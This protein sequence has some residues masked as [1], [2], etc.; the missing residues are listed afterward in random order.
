MAPPFHFGNLSLRLLALLVHDLF[1]VEGVGRIRENQGDGIKQR[2]KAVRG[3]RRILLWAVVLCAGVAAARDI[4]LVAN[5]ANDASS[6]SM[7]DLSKIC[8]GQMNR[9]PDGKPVTLIMRDPGAPEM[10]LVLDKVYG[11][12]KS[13]VAGLIVT[14]NH[15]RANHPAIVVVG[16]DEDLVN[17][18]QATPGS[19]GLVDVYSINGGI[20]VLKLGGKLPL[21]PG[22]PLHGN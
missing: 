21:E 10:K 19:V 9:W 15:G 5:K 1:G 12:N 4:A 14:A 7:A 2:R 16:S 3:L 18:V 6:V 22:Y 13:D 17:K 20:T 8:K 11:M